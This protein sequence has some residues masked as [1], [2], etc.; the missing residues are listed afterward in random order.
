M[1]Y[2]PAGAPARRS[3]QVLT[4][5]ILVPQQ[6]CAAPREIARHTAEHS[7]RLLASRATHTAVQE[8]TIESGQWSSGS[9][10]AAAASAAAILSAAGAA[11]LSLQAMGTDNPPPTTSNS[12]TE[13]YDGLSFVAVSVNMRKYENSVAG[14]FQSVLILRRRLTRCDAQIILELLP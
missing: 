2:Q 10:A 9:V 11:T 3:N 12:A 1:S 6:M 4:V 7:G 8:T 5:G 13:S 14:Y